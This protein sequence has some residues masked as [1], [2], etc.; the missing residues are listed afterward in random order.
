MEKLL[1][2]IIYGLVMLVLNK[3]Q[4]KPNQNLDIDFSSF[5]NSKKK[6][7]TKSSLNA[8][9]GASFEPINYKSREPVSDEFVQ[10]MLDLGG[11]NM[12][13]SKKAKKK[14]EAKPAAPT[15]SQTD[16]PSN[17]A[18]TKKLAAKLDSVSAPTPEVISF[19][20]EDIL[21]AFVM[22]ELMQRYDLNRIYERIPAAKFDE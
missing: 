13:S 14:K 2:V 16:I 1:F 5:G 8:S 6:S 17:I 10:A 18:L 4:K 20:R 19:G 21:K 3:K 15:V 22:K 9:K 12:A 11:S 7:G